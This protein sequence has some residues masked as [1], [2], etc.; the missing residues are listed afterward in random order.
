MGVKID[1]RDPE[2][3]AQKVG[4][5]NAGVVDVAEAF[6]VAS[7]GMMK[8]PENVEHKVIIFMQE[9]LGSAVGCAGRKG[10]EII[11]ALKNGVFISAQSAAQHLKAEGVGAGGLQQAQIFIA[12]EQGELF[13]TERL[14]PDN[15]YPGVIKQSVAVAELVDDFGP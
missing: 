14:G 6:R 11:E 13:K 2:P 10:Y 5:G 12:V 7:A 9:Q 4:D 8:A 15:V 1:V 3:L